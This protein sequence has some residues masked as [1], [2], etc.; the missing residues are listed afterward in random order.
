MPIWRN[1]YVRVRPFRAPVQ[2]E[3][4]RA[5]RQAI[6]GQREDNSE[7]GQPDQRYCSARSS[8]LRY[9]RHIDQV[10]EELERTDAAVD[11]RVAVRTRRARTKS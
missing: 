8:R 3:I 2:L 5:V 7:I 1:T 6:P 10:V 11:D 4:H 9:D